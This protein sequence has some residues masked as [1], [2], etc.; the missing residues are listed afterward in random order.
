MY[1]AAASWR[2][3]WYARDPNRVRRLSRPVISVGNLRVGGSGKTPVVASLAQML[4]ALGERPAILSRG[5]GRLEAP[6]GVTV[7]SDGIS[8]RAGLRASGDEP[9]MLARNL[10][11][12]RVVVAA[13]RFLAGTLAERQLGATVHLLDDG[14]QHVKLWRDVD[15]LL[16][17]EDD[18]SDAV[19][20]AGRLREPL[21]NGSRADAVLVPAADVE[22]PLRI[23]KHLGVSD[24]FRVARSLGAPRGLVPGVQPPAPARAVAVAGIAR[25]LRFFDDVKGAGIEVAAAMAFRDHHA[26]S[27]RD[28]DR[29]VAR[30]GEVGARDVVTTEKDAVRLEGLSWRGLSVVYLPLVAQVEPA[31]RFRAWLTSRMPPRS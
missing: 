3:E 21:R 17:D 4:V 16:V 31:D 2:R 11:G 8:V 13:D 23:A 28:V 15:L 5:Y 6:D 12:V 25:P 7:V 9:L 20:P 29:I 18:L 26:Y 1:G 10:P 27:Q 14:F 30:A 19:L 22:A 24:A